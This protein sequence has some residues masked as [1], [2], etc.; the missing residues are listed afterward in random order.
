LVGTEVA[1]VLEVDDQ[2]H[3]DGFGDLTQAGLE[4]GGVSRVGAGKRH[5]ARKAVPPEERRLVQRS[6]ERGTEAGDRPV[7]V[8]EARQPANELFVFAQRQV[9]KE[10]VAAVDEPAEAAGSHVPQQPMALD[11]VEAAKAGRG[12]R[13]WRRGD[14]PGG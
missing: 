12:A 8:P 10:G 13:Q 11:A 6:A 1:F 7:L 9:I 5:G 4:A 2:T 14:G 3:A